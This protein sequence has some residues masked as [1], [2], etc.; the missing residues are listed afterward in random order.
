V[1]CDI[2]P[3]PHLNIFLKKR[4]IFVTPAKPS[5]RRLKTVHNPNPPDILEIRRTNT[6][7]LARNHKAAQPYPITR[8]SFLPLSILS[9]FWTLN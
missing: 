1:A 3:Y 7:S 6:L 4:N 2:Q 9:I 5:G 8:S